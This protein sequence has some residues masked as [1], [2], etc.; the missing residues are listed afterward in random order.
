MTVNKKIATSLR[1]LQEKF[2]CNTFVLGVSGGP[3][4]QCLLK[5]FSHV[6]KSVDAEV[7]AC[8]IDHGLRPG[9]AAELDIAERLAESVGV[10]FR[11]VVLRVPPGA[12]LQA[13]AR[14]A[15]Y[16]ALHDFCREVGGEVL[17]LAHHERDKAETVLIRLLRGKGAGALAVMPFM[18]WST[19]PLWASN[20][21]VSLKGIPITPIVRFRPMLQVT[22]EEIEAYLKRWNVPFALDPSNENEKFLRVWVRKKLLPMLESKSPAI[23]EKLCMIAEDL[24]A[25]DGHPK[26]GVPGS[27]RGA[28]MQSE[29]PMNADVEL[30]AEEIENPIQL[31]EFV[32]ELDEVVVNSIYSE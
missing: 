7:F 31:D 18:S 30:G 6:A 17:V 26:M 2:P 23:V 32:S 27:I 10:P 1:G 19:C 3:D 9:A 5:A 8:G 15:R 4:S 16:D 13:R 21:E 29:P 25:V 22:K 12:N 11:R 28:H 24:D 14:D 20:G